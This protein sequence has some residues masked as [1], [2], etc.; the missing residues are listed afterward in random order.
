MMVVTAS[1]AATGLAADPGPIAS[2]EYRLS[3]EKS[4]EFR[5]AP[6]EPAVPVP[7]PRKESAIPP[8]FAD[9]PFAKLIDVAARDAALDPALVHAVI[10]IE[11]GYNAAARSPKGALGLMQVLPETAA[12]YGVTNAGRSPEANLKAGTLYLSDLLQMFD[13]RMDLALAAYNAGENAVIRYGERIPPYRE[14]QLYVP[15]V[16]ARYLEWREEPLPVVAPVVPTRI[17]Y[18]SGTSLDLDFLQ[19]AGYR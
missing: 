3:V 17:Q 12:R 15:A 16:L 4:V 13:N 14:T 1:V 5:A 7:E 11:S 19:A 8:R 6:K 2:P 9:R 18:L 10:S